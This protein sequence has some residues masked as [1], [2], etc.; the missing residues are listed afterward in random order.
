MSRRNGYL[1]NQQS[2][3]NQLLPQ[4]NETQ[5]RHTIAKLSA[6]KNRYYLSKTGVNAANTIK[7]QW[8]YL[9]RKRD[10]IKVEFFHHDSYP[11]PSVIMSIP[12][13]TKPNEIVVIGGHLDSINGG[14]QR[15]TAS[16]P[17]ADDNASGIATITEIIRVLLKNNVYPERTIQFMGYAAEEI[18]L[19]GSSDIAA[20]YRKHDK[21]VIGVVQ[22]DMTNFQGS[23]HDI[24]LMKDFTDSLQNKFLARLASV[25]LPEMQ[26]GYS[27]CGYGCSDHASWTANGY[28]ASFPF[29]ATMNKLNQKIHS[30]K[31]TLEQ[32]GGH[33]LHAH[34]FAKL[35]MAYVVEMTKVASDNL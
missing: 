6:Y 5:I 13:K 34:K 3:V 1:I 25:Y 27:T 9:A 28:P 11:Q 33:A 29:E 12:G 10:D 15:L 18:G 16:A 21:K 22:F 17:G 2:L 8:A 14:D 30:A 7:R 19:L 4:V 26:V 20:G 35:G 23:T 24:V 32:S 31:D